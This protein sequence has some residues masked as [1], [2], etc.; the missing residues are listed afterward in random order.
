[1]HGSM[2]HACIHSSVDYACIHSSVNYAYMH[3]SADHAW[4]TGGE[5][6]DSHEIVGAAAHLCRA[7][8]IQ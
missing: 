4:L 8:A 6:P 7:E 2:E 5:N 1:M 3:G